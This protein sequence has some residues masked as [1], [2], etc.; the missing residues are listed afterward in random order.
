MWLK[1]QGVVVVEAAFQ[2]ELELINL[3]IK[4]GDADGKLGVLLADAA[5]RLDF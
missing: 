5:P 1:L 2:C 4:H 3:L